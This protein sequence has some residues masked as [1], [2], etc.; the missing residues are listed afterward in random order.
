[1]KIQSKKLVTVTTE[2]D[3]HKFYAFEG[4]W[5]N[6]MI[7]RENFEEGNYVALSF[8]QQIT[9]GNSYERKSTLKD[10][11]DNMIKNN[12]F[13]IYEF[14]NVKSMLRWLTKTWKN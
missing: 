4:M 13:V 11:V 6:G 3:E 1:M 9:R 10:L 5:G 14:T 12:H 8:R 2:L 7:T